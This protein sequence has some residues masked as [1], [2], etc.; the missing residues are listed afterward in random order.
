MKLTLANQITALRILLIIPFIL[1]MLRASQNSHGTAIRYVAFF[2]FMVMC[3]SDAIDGYFARVKKQVTRLGSF[4]DP[5]ADK[6]LITSACI[7]LASPATAV[8]G[9]AMPMAVVVLIIGKDVL[10]TLGVITVY[11]MTGSVRIEPVAAGKCTT[12]LQLSMVAAILVAPEMARLLGIWPHI[13][14][15]L[16]WTAASAA[17]LTMFVYIRRGIQYIER[18]EENHK[19]TTSNG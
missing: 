19:N 11:M 13:V 6:L 2:I 4:L 3:L 16:C 17:I 8:A 10:I 12:V 1:C 9:F 7:L 14:V 15:F 18:F 5:L